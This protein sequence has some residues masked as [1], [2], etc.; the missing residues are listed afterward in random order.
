MVK[1]KLLT[2]APLSMKL[3]SSYGSFF[4]FVVYM[5]AYGL[6]C[7]CVNVW[8]EARGQHWCFSLCCSPL[9]LFF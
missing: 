4:S 1:E 2:L 9:Y 5:C 8:D 3:S 7:M 6:L